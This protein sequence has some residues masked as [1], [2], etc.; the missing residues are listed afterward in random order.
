MF[1]VSCLDLSTGWP[2][3][4]NYGLGV[5]ALRRVQQQHSLAESLNRLAPVGRWSM[6]LTDR[7]NAGEWRLPNVRELDSLLDYGFTAR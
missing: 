1:V 5:A 2:V 6:R 3:S 7:S 4:Y